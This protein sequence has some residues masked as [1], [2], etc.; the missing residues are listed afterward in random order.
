MKQIKLLF[1]NLLLLT[2]TVSFYSANAQVDN[3]LYFPGGRSYVGVGAL[4]YGGKT[5]LTVSAWVANAL[6]TGYGTIIAKY[7][8]S[9]GP[10]EYIFRVWDRKV[11]LTLNINGV[12]RSVVANTPLNDNQFYHVAA[13]YDNSSMKIYIN[14]VLD[15]E[16]SQT[17]A[18]SNIT[19]IN[20]Y[21]GILNNDTES[22]LGKIDELS[23]W[24]RALSDCEIACLKD[25]KPNVY[26]EDLKAYY[27]FNQTSGTYLPDLTGKYNA[28]LVGGPYWTASGT[29][30]SGALPYIENIIT[31]TG[32]ATTINVFTNTSAELTEYGI[33]YGET[34]C[35]DVN[36]GTIVEGTD[37]SGVTFSALLE[38]LSQGSTYYARA[39]TVQNGLTSYGMESRFVTAMLGNGK[40]I[41]FDGTN[42]KI[43]LAVN[44]TVAN[45]FTYEFWIKPT[46]THINDQQSTSG[47][48]GVTAGK[49]YAIFGPNTQTALVSVGTNG[50]SVY[51]HA[52]NYMPALAVF[53]T[54]I[55][56]WTHVA[57][58]YINKTPHIYINGELKHIGLQSPQ[59]N[60]YADIE[61]LGGGAYG[62]FQGSMDEFRIWN[63]A[64]TQCQISS[65]Y[66]KTL[67]G[68]EP[69]LIGYYNFDNTTGTVLT[70]LGEAQNMGTLTN[71]SFN[72]YS[73][74]WANSGADI[75]ENLTAL[76]NTIG[77]NPISMGSSWLLGEIVFGN[78]TEFGFVYGKETC[79]TL[80]NGIKA[81]TPDIEFGTFN[82]E[83][84]DLEPGITYY[85]RAFATNEN[86]TSYGKVIPLYPGSGNALAFD[87][88]DDYLE[89]TTPVIPQSGEFSVSVWAKNNVALA[90][91][92]EIMSQG[93][94]FYLGFGGTAIRVGDAWG[95]AGTFPSDGAWHNYTVTR[96]ETNTFLYIDA[97]LVGS[98][99]SAI[100]NPTAVNLRVGRQYGTNAE[101]WSGEIDEVR[102]F[103]IALSEEEVLDWHNR[104]AFGTEW[105]LN[106]SYDFNEGTPCGYNPGTQVLDA[107]GL[108]AM[109]S[110]N[111]A[112]TLGNCTSNFILSSAAKA[113]LASITLTET[114][115]TSIN[116][117][118]DI[119]KTGWSP[120]VAE[121]GFVYSTSPNPD[122]T[123]FIVKETG[124]F[125][126]GTYSFDIQNLEPGVVYYV[127][128]YATNDNGTVFGEEKNISVGLV[129]GNALEFNGAN[130]AGAATNS[131]LANKS[132][133]VEFWAKP[134]VLNKFNYVFMQGG[135]P[136]T[137][138]TNNLLHIGFNASN[139]F[140]MNFYGNDLVS[141]NA[142]AR[143][144][145]NW[146]HWAATYDVQTKTRKIYK[147]GVLVGSQNNVASYT[148]TGYFFV[149]VYNAPNPMQYYSGAVDE[150]RVWNVARTD[151]EIQTNYKKALKGSEPGLVAAYDFNTLSAEVPDKSGNGLTLGKNGFAT[152]SP[153]GGIPSGALIIHDVNLGVAT[154]V[155][156]NITQKSAT[157]GGMI[158][159]GD[160]T[161]FGIVYNTTGCPT[162]LGSKTVA[163]NLSGNE[164]TAELRDL[165]AAT[166]YYTRAFATNAKGTVYGPEI[167]FSTAWRGAG[168]ALNFDGTDDYV[169]IGAKFDFPNNFSFEFWAKP[170]N[171]HGDHTE[172][173]TANI[174]PGEFRNVLSST[175]N[176]SIG[177]SVGTNGVTVVAINPPGYRTPLA[178]YKGTITE[179]THIAIVVKDKTPLIY[180]NGKLEHTGLRS[181]QP[182]V[183]IAS[184]YIGSVNSIYA[185]QLDE[186]RIWDR[187]LSETEI[188]DNMNRELFGNP[189]GLLAYYT[190]NQG[191][192]CSDN[193]GISS[194]FEKVSSKHGTFSN[195]LLSGGCGSN[196]VLSTLDVVVIDDTELVSKNNT[197][198]TIKGNIINL[199]FGDATV[200]GVCY[201][202]SAM[203]T[204]ESDVVYMPGEV[205][206]GEFEVV[207]SDL[208]S[209]T[210]YYARSFVTVSGYTTYGKQLR[211]ISNE[212]APDGDVYSPG[213]ITANVFETQ[214]SM[215]SKSEEIGLT[216]TISPLLPTGLS[217][218]TQT[219]EISGILKVAGSDVYTVTITNSGGL[220]TTTQVTIEGV[221]PQ[222][223]ETDLFA[224]KAYFNDYVELK[225]TMLHYDDEVRDFLI[226]RKELG[227]R[228]DS[229][230]VAT[231]AGDQRSWRD[232]YAASNVMY[233]YTV[234]VRYKISIPGTNNQYIHFINGVGFR[235]PTGTVSGKITYAGGH[236]VENV[237]VIAETTDNFAGKSI[238]LNGTDAFIE[239]PVPEDEKTFA[240]DA[241]FAFQAW[242][243]PE[244]NDPSTLMQK[245]E[246][247]K[248]MYSPGEI[249]F[250]AGTDT[251]KVNFEQKV[252]TF[253]N[254]TVMR[255]A[256]S[257]MLMLF[258]DAKN[259]ITDNK[260]INTATTANNDT[261]VIGS[262]YNSEF[263]R[264]NISEIRIWN[265]NFTKEELIA[266]VDRFIL[267]NEQGLAAYYRTDENFGHTI[268]D[269]S[270]YNFLFNEKHGKIHNGA[271]TTFT[272]LI[273]QLGVKGVTDNNG[274]YVIAGIPFA[275]A[276]STY[277]FVPMFG[278]HR[279]DPNEKTLIIASGATTHN[280]IDFTDVSSFRVTGNIKYENTYFPV[281]G[282]NFYID[283]QVV[284]KPDGMPVT[285]DAMGNYAIDVPIGEHSIRVAMRGH[286]F[287]I[288][289]FPVD[290]ESYFNFQEPFNGL[291]FTDITKVKLIG[292]VTGG[293]VE[294]AKP[295]AMGRTINNL[296]IA[297]IKL[298]TQKLSE[299]T[300]EGVSVI[301]DNK[302][303]KGSVLTN[304]GKTG[305]EINKLT[306]TEISIMPDVETGEFEVYLLPEKYIITGIN[307]GSYTFGTSFNT[308]VDLATYLHFNETE[309]DSV[310]I[311]E[312][313]NPNTGD[314]V[315]SYRI[316]SVAYNHHLNLIYRE[317][318]QIS[319][320]SKNGNEIF[321]ETEY[322]DEK[323]RVTSLLDEDGNSLID[324]PVFLQ[325]KL[326]TVKVSVFEEYINA[327]KANETTLVPVTDGKLK[328][329]NALSLADS[330][331][332]AIDA[333]GNALYS[334]AGGLPNL[335]QGGVGDYLLP[336][337]IIAKTGQ[338]GS[339]LTQWLYKGA[340]FLGYV[341]GGKP[342]GDN[343]VTTG[344]T[345][346]IMI[347]R[348]PPGTGS[349]ASFEKGKSIS[350]TTSHEITNEQSGEAAVKFQFGAEVKIFAGI[351]VGTITETEYNNNLTVGFE[352]SETWVNSKETSSTT[353]TTETWSTSDGGD[354]VG[355]DGDV[356]VGYAT[357][358]VYGPSLFLSLIP[359][360]IGFDHTG[361]AVN[362]LRIGKEKGIRVNPKFET[363]FQYT[364]YHIE[365]FLIPNL[366]ML[367]N[368]ILENPDGFYLSVLDKE[369]PL[370]GSNN[371]GAIV[372][373]T[374]SHYGNSYIYN[375]PITWDR[376]K[377]FVDSVAFYNQQIGEWID[378]LARNEREKLEATTEYNL[379][380]DAGV[381][382]S[383][384]VSNEK[385]ETVNKSFS[386]MISPSL[387]FETGFTFNKF[388]IGLE[389]K[390]AYK[391]EET[392]TTGETTTTSSTFEYTLSDENT[393]DYF[394]V[395]VKKPKTQ[396]GPVF[397]T[398]GGQTMCPHEGS[399]E[400][401][402]YKPGTLI[403]QATMKREVAQIECIE[404]TQINVP[405]TMPAFYS[406]QLSN[407]SETDEDMWMVITV[408]HTSNPY[409]ALVELDGA[410]INSGRD[411][412]L[413]AG[414]A[415]NKTLTI[416]QVRPD[417]Y[418][419][420]NIAVVL[421]SQ[422][423][424]NVVDTLFL[425]ALFQPVCTRVSMTNPDDLWVVNTATDSTLVVRIADYN[426]ANTLFNKLE[427]QYKSASSANWLVDMT[428]YVNEAD[429]DAANE[430]KM[431]IDNKPTLSHV[432]DMKSFA[433][434]NYEIKVVSTCVDGTTNNSAIAT[435][436]KDVKRPKVF[437]TPQPAG[438]ILTSEDDVMIA[439]DESINAGQLRSYNFSVRGVVNGNPI[440]HQ[441][442]LYFD[443]IASY[444]SAVN[445]IALENKSWTIEFWARRGNL[446][447][448]VI[449][450]QNG[451]EIG[452]DASNKMYAKT[453]TQTITSTNAVTSLT[454]WNHYAVTYNAASQSF[455]LFIND[456]IE[457]ESVIQTSAFAANGRMN[458]G[459]STT[460]TKFFN[461]YL[462]E[463][464][465]WEKA[466]SLGTIYS[467]MEVALAGNELGLSGYWPM[468]E[469]SGD[470]AAD[471]SRSRNAFL[472]GAQWRV[473]PT[474]YA[475]V[476]NG[477]A[478]LIINTSA[479]VISDQ[480]DFSIEF[481]FKAGPQQNTVLYSSGK[482]DGTDVMPKFKHIW[483]IGFNESGKLYAKNNGAIMVVGNDVANNTWN[484]FALVV[485][486]NANAQI[487]I[488]G[489]LQA[490]EQG[491]LF[492]G[493]ESAKVALGARIS[494]T[495]ITTNFDQ[496]FNGS[497]DEFRI[498]KLAKTRKQIQLDMNSKLQGTEMGLLAYYPFDKYNSLGIA[499]DASLEDQSTTNAPD[500]IATG[501]SATNV[502]VPNI[503]DARPVKDLL[504]DWVVNDDKVIFNI[505]ESPALIEKSLLEFSIER[506]ED[507]RGNLMESAATWTAYVNRNSV[508]WDEFEMNIS[509]EVFAEFSFQTKIR[510]TGGSVQNYNITGLPNWLTC[511]AASGAL[512]PDSDKNITFT[513]DPVV[514]IGTYELA[515]FLT[516]DFGYSEKLNLNIIVFKS[517][518]D[519]FV[520]SGDFQYSMNVIGELKIDGEFSTNSS[521]LLAAFVNGEC[522]G[523]AQNKYVSEYDK[524]M[525]FMNIYSNVES[526]ET[527][528]FKIWNASEGT[529]HINV[530][531]IV[532]FEFNKVIG[533]PE[534]PQLIE[535]N[536][537]Y[538][539]IQKLNAGWSWIS[540]NLR[541]DN[542]SNV[543]EVMSEINAQPGDQ[544]KG[545]SSYADYS[546]SLGWDGSLV[547]NGG[548]DNKS[549]YMFKLSNANTLTYWG[550]RLNPNE[551]IIPVKTGWN[552]I[553]YTSHK[554]MEVNEAF[555]NYKP[556]VGDVIKSQFQFSMYDEAL[557][558]VGSL[559]YMAPGQG[560]MFNT[561]NV[562][563]TLSFP[564]SGLS[565]AALTEAVYVP[566]EGTPWTLAE[567]K[568]QFNM[569]VVA[570]LENA[571]VLSSDNYAVAVFAGNECRGMAI[572]TKVNNEYLLYLTVYSDDAQILSF[573]VIDLNTK[574]IFY[575]NE[576]LSFVPNA[577]SG[578]TSTPLL[579]TVGGTLST[580]SG[581][582]DENQ[583]MVSVYPNPFADLISVSCNLPNSG[584]VSIEIFDLLGKKLNTVL[585]SNVTKGSHTFEIS[586]VVLSPGVYMIKVTSEG[587]AKT[588]RI[589]RQ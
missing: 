20:S 581:L 370:Y 409:G 488:N 323:G 282:V 148:G 10:G 171:T 79:I 65:E 502:D 269:R 369:D 189:N 391:H 504:F 262:S 573:Q 516:A 224:S 560:Y 352:H 230:R 240:F 378:L 122:F 243:K 450:A 249:L 245:G 107:S 110:Y 423:D 256:D 479:A 104:A 296:G 250:K 339:I 274:S 2:L 373:T 508:V 29:T 322:V 430:P 174:A 499:L 541:N 550:A 97:A 191:L 555:A 253:F 371:I 305:V 201:S 72:G 71:F 355:A 135:V 459:K 90:G 568:H 384:S 219:G 469:A 523:V 131:L 45:N 86:G 244:S 306:P 260:A 209:E 206:A 33:V 513:V 203:P 510:N 318:P 356:F 36:S 343:F 552:W 119:S 21:I 157:V 537:S 82:V 247:Y 317:I 448:G 478:N 336:M 41:A 24:S 43:T 503:K 153:F 214:I 187:S 313:I 291:N 467:Q 205:T 287:E 357:N 109:N 471:K 35:L 212:G 424:G 333:K 14:G 44:R 562:A 102:V 204:I 545:I 74:G 379:S 62:Y 16:A 12:W 495:E 443:G 588:I 53:S 272:P 175:A 532:D 15:A 438:G 512:D 507:L 111:M 19:Y 9:G 194:L 246:Q 301:T 342:Y 534:A 195:M 98:K 314:T 298:T 126:A 417:I 399:L 48:D 124:E 456:V 223:F 302:Y 452:F 461:G 241:N 388:G 132:F 283:G 263:F 360:T 578:T 332:L 492:G 567:T 375:I 163:S 348:D 103:N 130:F 80:E 75:T 570:K 453:G 451:I 255:S 177:V 151:C 88:A 376:T 473:F 520:N 324:Y 514:N 185:G 576:K 186:V 575:I 335:A 220:S 67:T 556:K 180:L 457:K 464:R 284:A 285:S 484:H 293:P 544:I 170:S 406:I 480:T 210:S 374:G 165:D 128:A 251:L 237:N 349:S 326:Y 454:A 239:I 528:K 554:N 233:E 73:S 413:P 38:G 6:P 561:T 351:G 447:E 252:D 395:D 483:N 294:A 275:T 455:N 522:R 387:A 402:Y 494:Y 207:L 404:K 166:W 460:N 58:V 257:L 227:S 551:E 34:S 397:Y 572:V 307:A 497:I 429:F 303:Y 169:S 46:A 584:N 362:G 172:S 273:N 54:S 432:L 217:I 486:R 365:N 493:I 392:K 585:N 425:T 421:R 548:F 382:Y 160:A 571:S 385:S 565:K 506:V 491:S 264:G 403:R 563:G 419:Y 347:L 100:P 436:I 428:Y 78:A 368:A 28:G 4:G 367:R 517:A 420:E 427:V 300:T 144:D 27:N 235:I 290:P 37:Y 215:V 496:A 498:W 416:K 228:N 437:G 481:Y 485:N 389:L 470:L 527:V 8:G 462:H 39:Y 490:Y 477:S 236:S 564:I 176:N 558:W 431:F 530:T 92:R 442:C 439:F 213:S 216:Y 83:I 381:N 308:T 118:A 475:R 557:G 393:G 261:L 17:G 354:F 40:A 386:F 289:R 422:C 346:I 350:K 583:F 161:E 405:A 440:G 434:R 364:Q 500:A 358:L 162:I 156:S 449:F 509:K 511:N 3:A 137:S 129:P 304:A 77:G 411:I 221:V 542:L 531:P 106:A 292:R 398:R 519:W 372:D 338:N 543:D 25:N 435:G 190:M 51:E 142:E 345:E 183:Y 547:D 277:K 167:M 91:Y 536:N 549:M 476:F 188:H 334:F 139:Q 297:T 331:E 66:K 380:F 89:A 158:L 238:S 63:Y 146:H 525:V 211:F 234:W 394:S 26:D 446:S 258:Y 546:A 117:V 320:T 138:T 418:N 407:L 218:D 96:S 377:A 441:S 168:N 121:R 173:A 95:N 108:T 68:F 524:Y 463:F 150:L 319:V 70:D 248:I 199:G 579:L 140:C 202:L 265:S 134:S 433:D 59:A 328:I 444:A 143:T 482:G 145:A 198:A 278:I 242:F 22:F 254:V 327:D 458:I 61:A 120:L 505:K 270:G 11:T 1:I 133:T 81:T 390:E 112:R 577:I 267:G 340:S 268:F 295:K 574:A 316:D 154:G 136:P 49:R 50:V 353:T 5:Q 57:V 538:N 178:V 200:R 321:W 113:Q 31:E 521:D 529:E 468:D 271:W 465:I 84:A 540:F 533:S 125:E 535:S 414:Q 127:K 152:A 553:S 472:Y 94:N 415:I 155:E 181:Q 232:E 147:D 64:R 410:E 286:E 208:Q 69:G 115:A 383:R 266:K 400:T 337:S 299:L 329:R 309:K 539:F 401:K 408:D 288:D 487:F 515:L 18:I 193:T 192:S 359:D 589:V 42:D 330:T 56:D 123:D 396:T 226:F 184:D 526:G 412:Y 114:S 426:L 197:S 23:L 30:V 586:D 559:T 518:P 225:W 52:P 101:F 231:V 13:T 325:R 310:V 344:P 280:N 7:Q 60:V 341:L 259:Y 366:A 87:G 229:V 466:L 569:S 159:F 47:A 312:T 55:S 76:V 279:F 93:A 361:N 489:E 141:T 315:Y 311:S 196:F 445:G 566:I 222:V 587:A 105:E 363:G 276:G 580:E 582:T 281:E 99:G 501:G 85:A 149:G 182:L 116:A 474:G 164:F 179:W 32:G